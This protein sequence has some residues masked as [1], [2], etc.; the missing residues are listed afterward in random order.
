MD[1]PNSNCDGAFIRLWCLHQIVVPSSDCGGAFIRLWWCLHQII[2]MNSISLFG[3]ILS[4]HWLRNLWQMTAS[5]VIALFYLILIWCSGG[6]TIR[7]WV[8]H[9]LSSHLTS[10]RY[11]RL[12]NR[13]RLWPYHSSFSLY[14]FPDI[15]WRILFPYLSSPSDLLHLLTDPSNF[16]EKH[17]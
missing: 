15:P 10:I 17:G 4:S 3:H 11:R 1:S 7:E 14:S 16:L 5:L 8:L 6:W 13:L 2:S 9:I 12:P